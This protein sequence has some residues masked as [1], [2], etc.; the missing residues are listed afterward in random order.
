[1]KDERKKRGRKSAKKKRALRRRRRMALVAGLLAAVLLAMAA[2]TVPGL[3]GYAWGAA[4][5]AAAVEAILLAL[6]R[7]VPAGLYVLIG[8]LC[9]ALIA[10]GAATRDLVFTDK[11]I[12]PQE[13]LVTELT[14][15]GSWPDHIERYTGLETLD[16]RNSTVT[17][18]S[19]VLR[20]RSLRALDARGNTAFDEATYAEI[21]AALPECAI[22]WSMSLAGRYYDS[23][24][25][26]VDLSGTG[27]DADEI[28]ELQAEHPDIDFTY[29]VPLMGKEID[30]AATA[31]DLRGAETVDPDAILAALSLLPNAKRVDLRDAPVTLDVAEAL[32]NGCPDVEFSFTFAIPGGSMDSDAETVTLP[33]GTYDD[34]R[35]AM[36][37]I[38]YMPRLQYLDARA[39][40]MNASEQEALRS[41][42]AS[43]KVLYNFTV[44]GQQVNLLTTALNLDNVQIGGRDTAEQV[45]AALPNLRTVSMVGCGLTQEDMIALCEAHPDIHF[46]WVVQF[47]KY[48]LR[49]D[50]TAFTTNLYADNKDHYTS[51]TFQVLKYCTDL[52]ML[53]LG[54]CDITDLDFIAPMTHLKVLILADNEITDISVL[55]DKSELQYA[56][57]FLNKITDLS[58]LANKPG[59]LDLNI[60]YNPVQDLSPLATDIA[61]ERLWL[62]QCS[63][64]NSQIN[65]IKQALPNCKVNAKGSSSTGNGWREHRRYRTLKEMY[66][67][68]S[69]I[70]FT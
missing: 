12:V 45:F 33:G 36:G 32:M 15:S 60:Y 58:P 31:I 5:L 49:T 35:T 13:S 3:A 62:G 26:E 1:M 21:S 70:P 22:D 38:P 69:F 40:V 27:L 29:T 56:E 30:P 50:A 9:V 10:L 28:T 64:P 46:I 8:A 23:G 55:S 51:D 44:Y 19:P 7:G 42:P 11:G 43:G 66:K 57:L 25:T 14:V 47:G 39:I 61:L 68:G 65:A 4:A 54:H 6:R 20:M 67:T 16:L 34:L 24:T 48:Q 18:F 63:L 37:F 59:L 41:D 2:N 53:D 17:D 52:Q